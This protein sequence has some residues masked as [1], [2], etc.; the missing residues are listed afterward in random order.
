MLQALSALT[1]HSNRRAANTRLA[2][3]L[4]RTLPVADDL[5][6]VTDV[7]REAEVAPES[8]GLDRATVDAIWRAAEDLYCT[9]YYPAIMLCLRRRGQIVLN[10]AIG[11]ASGYAPESGEAPRPATVRT[12]ACIYSASKAVTAMLMHKLAEE[13]RIDL[14]DPVSYYIP[15]FARHGKER[16][17]LYHLLTHR[18]GVPTIPRDMPVDA[19]IDQQA[20]LQAICDARPLDRHGSTQ[21]YHALTAGT[22]LQAVLERVTGEGIETYW[23]SRFKTPMRFESFGYGADAARF[24]DL[25]RDH[26]SGARLPR[27]ATHYLKSLLGLDIE[28]DW[29]VVNEPRFFAQPIPAANMIATA[30][31]L[32]RFF[33]MLMDEGRYGDTQILEPRTVHHAIWESFPHRFDASLKVPVRMSA[34]MMLGGNPLGLYGWKS[35][36]AFGHL[37][38]INTFGWADPARQTAI[39]LLTTGKPILAHSWPFLIRLIDTLSR[40][41]PRDAA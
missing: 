7:D 41:L 8:V 28:H 3:R 33:Q 13:G 12:P 14:L 2:Q 40:R 34:G 30:E 19:V 25:A 35:E 11:F 24:S 32:G 15:E 16:I 27:P 29:R 31:E 5:A 37:G 38:F 20:M 23:E 1:R 36:E 17:N 6:T 22:V 9:G 18:G 10:R 4:L 21:A 39:G 26:L